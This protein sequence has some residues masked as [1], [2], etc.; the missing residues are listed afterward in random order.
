MCSKGYDLLFK[1][2]RCE[3]RKGSKIVIAIGKKLEGNI[4]QPKGVDGYFFMTQINDN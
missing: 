3:I 2:E 4:Y 1:D